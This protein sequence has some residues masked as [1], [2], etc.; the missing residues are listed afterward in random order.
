MT[1]DDHEGL[2]GFRGTELCASED[3]HPGFKTCEGI[4]GRGPYTKTTP[5][6]DCEHFPG[7]N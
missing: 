2:P 3:E 6:Q 1:A 7:S 5:G 4:D